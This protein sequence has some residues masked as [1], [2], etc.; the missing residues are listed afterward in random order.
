MRSSMENKRVAFLAIG[1]FLA[2]NGLQLA[3][4]RVDAVN[5]IVAVAA[6]E[7]DEPLLAAWIQ[8]NSTPR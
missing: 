2:N 3:A 6:G 4:D 8:R 5:T 7:L 1:V